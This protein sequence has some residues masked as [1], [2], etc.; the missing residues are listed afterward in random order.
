M[1]LP[2]DSPS[3]EAAALA[4]TLAFLAHC[5]DC[6]LQLD[7]QTTET[8]FIT[9]SATGHLIVAVPAAT[10]FAAQHILHIPDLA[11]DSLKLVVTPE[12]IEDCAQTDR[13]LAHFPDPHHLRFAQCYIDSARHG[14]WVFDGDAMMQPNPLAPIESETCKKLNADKAQLIKLCD[15]FASRP[16]EDPTCVALDPWGLSIRARFGIVRIPLDPSA[17][18]PDSA[19]AALTDLLQR[20]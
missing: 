20:V 5:S 1:S 17:N 19:R 6:V 8:N 9:D 4:H 7:D 2:T 12:E 3:D 13:L 10:F 16:V 14:P 18:D 15:K 11:D